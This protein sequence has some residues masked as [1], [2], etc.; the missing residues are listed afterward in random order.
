MAEK[1]SDRLSP[2]FKVPIKYGLVA[3]VINAILMIILLKSGRHPLLIP[4]Y[5]DARII[6]FLIFIYFSIREFKEFHNN[7]ILHM[8]QGLIIGM[9]TY[10]IVG[11]FGSFFIIIYTKFDPSFLTGYIESA[12][13]GA[14]IFKEELMAGERGVSMTEE[15]YQNH[16]TQLKQTSANLLAF[17][18]FIKSCLLGFFI[19]LIYSVLFRRTEK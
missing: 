15:E 18:Y 8:W 6:I 14:E 17:D 16:I 7:G 9:V 5:F 10:L 3:T 13:R 4:P 1:Y 19:P 2:M 11:F 12:I